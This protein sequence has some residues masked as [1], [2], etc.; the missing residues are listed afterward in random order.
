MKQS[1]ALELVSSG[2]I[3]RP[4]KIGR[5]LRLS[6]GLGC[7]FALYQLFMSHET[8]INNPVSTLPNMVLIVGAAVC[9]VNYVVNIGFGMNWGRWPSI[10]SI[11]VLGTI[12]SV[13][14]LILDTPD[15][16]MLGVVYW[17]WLFYFYLHLGTSFLIASML[18][19]PGCEMRAIPELLGRLSGKPAEEHYCPVA[20]ITKVDEWEAGLKS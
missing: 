19:T 20:L 18:A 7:Y 16:W 6:L 10:L 3:E 11:S 8:I 15:H 14:W 9:I 5:T 1:D 13:N 4:G 17:A 12:A 2:S